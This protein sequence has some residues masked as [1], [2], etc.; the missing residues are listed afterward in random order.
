MPP[1]KLMTTFSHR[2]P[3]LYW[4]SYEHLAPACYAR[5]IAATKSVLWH[6]N[7]SA[8]EVPSSQSLYDWRSVGRSVSQSVLALSPS[9]T[10]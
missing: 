1:K 5:R 4:T 3:R 7:R 9:G 6:P 2:C 8:A 10:H